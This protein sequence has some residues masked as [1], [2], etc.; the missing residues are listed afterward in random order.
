MLLDNADYFKQKFAEQAAEELRVDDAK[1]L[2]RVLVS[3]QAQLECLVE[4]VED[5][6]KDVTVC[7]SL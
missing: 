7:E 5:N 2:K 3:N 4:L 1:Q 6:K